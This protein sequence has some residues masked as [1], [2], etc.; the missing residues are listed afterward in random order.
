VSAASRCCSL[1]GWAYLSSV[2][3]IRAWPSRLLTTSTPMPAAS[4]QALDALGQLRGLDADHPAVRLHLL[5]SRT[6]QT[7]ALLL[8]TLLDADSLGYHLNE[9]MVLLN[10]T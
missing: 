5:T 4:E 3:L 8:D 9:I 7:Q 2:T 1:S 6:S 10:L